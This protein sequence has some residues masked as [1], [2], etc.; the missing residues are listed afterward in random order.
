MIRNAI[1]VILFLMICRDSFSCDCKNFSRFEE[2]QLS[3]I[4]MLGKVTHVIQ[5]EFSI[6]P[7]EIFK[8]EINNSTI[9]FI[10]ADDCSINPIEGE[11]GLY[12]AIKNENSYYISSCGYSRSFKRPYHNN[13]VPPPPPINMPDYLLFYLDQLNYE[14]ALSELY[15]D[16]NTLRQMKMEDKLKTIH[17]DI[18]KIEGGEDNIISNLLYVKWSVQI[19]IA[20]MLFFIVV[21]FIKNNSKT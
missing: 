11:I 15:F 10:I 18:L 5:K 21:I 16:I 7:F 8:G 1:L 6:I 19:L 14:R 9:N 4:V 12:Y 17:N 3:E 13:Y 20:I 2:Y